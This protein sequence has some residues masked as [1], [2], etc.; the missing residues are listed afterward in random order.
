MTAG[1]GRNRLGVVVGFLGVALWAAG[2]ARA[3]LVW[4]D[5]RADVSAGFGGVV[6]DSERDVAGVDVAAERVRERTIELAGQQFLA[7][8]VES[9]ALTAVPGGTS[10]G[11][12]AAGRSVARTEGGSGVGRDAFGTV[13]ARWDLTA[14]FTIDR[15]YT[16]ALTLDDG[17]PGQYDVDHTVRF[18]PGGGGPFLVDRRK[19]D[20][21]FGVV[22]ADGLLAA[23]TY[24]LTYG[25]EVDS[26]VPADHRYAIAL[27]LAP[28]SDPV[29]IPVPPAAGLALPALAALVHR[30]VR[31]RRRSRA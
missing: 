24:T 12:V 4:D 16:Y 31:A 22:A 27:D 8:A 2:T 18:G 17:G 29:P 11:L 10:T 5:L 28:A 9:A 30:Q 7:R 23:G 25:G 15:P 1:N 21:N 6:R 26:D 14:T 3:G 19:V 13:Y 20:E